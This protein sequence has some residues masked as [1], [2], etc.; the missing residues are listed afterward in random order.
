MKRFITILFAVFL[1]N[2]CFCA[3]D[4]TGWTE[5]D[6]YN[7]WSYSNPTP[8]SGRMDETAGSST[9]G[10]GWVIS[11]FTL[12]AVSSFSITLE[13]VGSGDDDFVGFVF[14]YQDNEHFYL[15]DWK[16]G[17]QGFNWGDPVTVNDDYA[18]QGIKLKKIDGSWT[19][20]GLWGGTDGADV[21]TL[22]GPTA[23][24]WAFNTPYTFDVELNSGH[25]VVE[26]DG[27]LL[28][29]ITDSS[30]QDGKIGLYG[31]S[32]DDLLFS[33]VVAI[34]EPASLL[35]LSLGGLLVRKR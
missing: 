11:D 29:D 2:Q 5:V 18:E 6:P 8:Q 21:S 16:K 24:G 13:V 22:T 14:G 9:V 30:F 23:G 25:I 33:G 28:F 4:M 20:D 34:P 1:V 27:T 32:Q 17:N 15:V 26:K 3:V 7:K 10:P 31:F 19:R 35:L 12:P